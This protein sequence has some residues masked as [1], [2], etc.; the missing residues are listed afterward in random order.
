[1]SVP[2]EPQPRTLAPGEFGALVTEFVQ[3][4]IAQRVAEQGITH[5]HAA[6]LAVYVDLAGILERKPEHWWQRWLT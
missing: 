1:M 6:L 5:Q 3:R 4:R 2:L